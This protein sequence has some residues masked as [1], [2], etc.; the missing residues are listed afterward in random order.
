MIERIQIPLLVRPWFLSLVVVGLI[1]QLAQKVLGWNIPIVHAYLDPL[2]FMP[3]LLHLTLWER[4][5][6]F[7][8]LDDYQ[9]EWWRIVAIFILASVVAEMVF[10]RLSTRFTADPYDVACYGLGAILYWMLANR[11]PTARLSG[12]SGEDAIPEKRPDE[13]ESIG[14]VPRHLVSHGDTKS[15]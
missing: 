6:L 7:R 5:V 4:R 12:R 1:H 2:L 10:P 15:H 8:A 3:I 13:Y 11:K 14:G 9:L